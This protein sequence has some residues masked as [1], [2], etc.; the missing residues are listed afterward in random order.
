VD[1]RRRLILDAG[2]AGGIAAWKAVSYMGGG[3][4]GPGT[5]FLVAHLVVASVV[6]VMLL[7]YL[8]QPSGVS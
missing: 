2:V 4:Y 3:F 1:E 8:A 7:T 5:V 6:F